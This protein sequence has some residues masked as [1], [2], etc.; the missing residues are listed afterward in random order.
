MRIKKK[1]GPLGWTATIL[2]TLYCLIAI[3]LIGNLILSSFKTKMDLVYNTFGFPKSFTL[4][5]YYKVLIKDDFIRYFYNSIVITSLSI[6]SLLTVSSMAAYGIARYK[7]KGKSIV[8]MYFLLG[9][10]FPIQ[11]AILPIFIILRNMH[12]LNTYS[13][14]ILLYTANLAFPVF[15]FSQFFRDLPAALHESALMDGAGEFRIFSQI[16]MPLS[17]PVIFTVAL[18]SFVQ[19][20]NDFYLPL[21]FLTKRSIRTVTLGIYH[22][23]SNFLAYWNYVFAAATIALVPIIIVFFIFS[24]QIIAGLVTGS[25]KE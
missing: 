20:W 3:F 16:M 25:I 5:N 10:M 2:L 11:I 17:R 22:Y 18:I 8:E 23:L 13:G 12:L 19:I 21:V 7:F 1:Q 4:G 24:D 14:M 15:I 9:L 6:I